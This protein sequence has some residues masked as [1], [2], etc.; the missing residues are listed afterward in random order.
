M[1]DIKKFQ[2]KYIEKGVTIFWSIKIFSDN[3]F[4]QMV[5]RS[6]LF[7]KVQNKKQNLDSR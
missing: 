3:S 6:S 5:T 1:F 7:I 4:L 2:N